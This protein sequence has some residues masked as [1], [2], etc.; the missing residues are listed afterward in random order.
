M[1]LS[2]S[3]MRAACQ[4]LA[5]RYSSDIEKDDIYSE[6]LLLKRTLADHQFSPT[7]LPL[8]LLKF[9]VSNGLGEVFSNVVTAY[10][11]LLTIPVSIATCE[12]SFSKLKLIKS[13]LR[14]TMGQDRLSSLSLLSIE[15][16]VAAKLS[17]E[18]VIGHFASVKARRLQ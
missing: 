16:E 18:K 2:K 12:R 13:H 1:A 4:L 7:S 10:T 17:L 14:S 8:D 11:L 15:S 9:I 6:F 5:E 3:E